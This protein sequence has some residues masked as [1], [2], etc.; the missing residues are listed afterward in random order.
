MSIYEDVETLEHYYDCD[1]SLGGPFFGEAEDS[2]I[3]I[4]G[5][6]LPSYIGSEIARELKSEQNPDSEQIFWDVLVDNGAHEHEFEKERE[7]VFVLGNKLYSIVA[8]YCYCN[9]SDFRIRMYQPDVE[10]SGAAKKMI[11]GKYKYISG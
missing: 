7:I 9:H 10:L 6:E 1:A 11:G 3:R 4:N 8:S 5:Y 2:T